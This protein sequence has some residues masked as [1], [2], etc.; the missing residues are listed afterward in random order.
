MILEKISIW[1]FFFVKYFVDKW[2]SH[3]I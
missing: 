3:K 2:K 1:I